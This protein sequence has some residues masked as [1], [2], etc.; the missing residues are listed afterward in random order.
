MKMLQMFI[1]I[2]VYLNLVACIWI[3]ILSL[4]EDIDLEDL[5][6]FDPHSSVDFIPL[7]E[8]LKFS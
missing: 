6:N 7:P 3:S 8:K 4:P 1:I 5:D 2:F